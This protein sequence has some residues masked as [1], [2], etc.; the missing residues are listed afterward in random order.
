MTPAELLNRANHMMMK[1]KR[2]T[3]TGSSSWL[4]S[5][6]NAVKQ[7]FSRKASP[8]P[9]ENG[10]MQQKLSSVIL[11]EQHAQQM[12]KKTSPSKASTKTGPVHSQQMPFHSRPSASSISERRSQTPRS[13]VQNTSSPTAKNRS[14]PREQPLSKVP[15]P[16]QV[17]KSS[18]G[19]A[20]ELQK[21]ATI[22]GDSS[23]QMAG[24][25][26]SIGQS[27]T[28]YSQHLLER[29]FFAR[30][31]QAVTP[32]T[33]GTSQTLSC[34]RSK[35]LGRISSQQSVWMG[36]ALGHSGISKTQLSTLHAS[37]AL[38]TVSII[39]C[40]ISVLQIMRSALGDN[41]KLSGGRIY[42]KSPLKTSGLSSRRLLERRSHLRFIAG[43]R[44]RRTTGS[45]LM[46]MRTANF[47]RNS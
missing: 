19:V 42:L 39:S 2:R 37:F 33:C 18:E 21:R 41:R 6:R 36:L 11:E 24:I 43:S 5:S 4:Q 7:I 30:S 38:R 44:I 17:T 20:K 35:S 29:N 12:M 26:P 40:R 47:T 1:G 10:L 15:L 32:R 46:G 13:L 34:S 9:L 3:K 22:V 8:L 27:S 16:Q 14:F 28:S 23:Y 25:R 31:T 45:Q